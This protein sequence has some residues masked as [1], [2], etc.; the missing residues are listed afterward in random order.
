MLTDISIIIE[1]DHTTGS[2][3]Y[4]FR[5][6]SDCSGGFRSIPDRSGPVRTHSGP[7]G[8]GPERSGPVRNPKNFAK[9]AEKTPPKPT[10]C[11]P[12]FWKSDPP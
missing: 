12:T 1:Y 8:T 3:P 4:S 5:I 2:I 7:F 10:T 9:S 11:A 6:I